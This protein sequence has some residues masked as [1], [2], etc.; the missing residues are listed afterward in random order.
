VFRR[1][2]DDGTMCQ[3]LN[4]RFQRRNLNHRSVGSGTVLYSRWLNATLNIHDKSCATMSDT[5]AQAELPKYSMC[6]GCV[7]TSANLLKNANG[8]GLPQRYRCLYADCAV[9]SCIIVVCNSGEY[10]TTALPSSSC[11]PT[12]LVQVESMIFG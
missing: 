2:R 6:G 11:A 1:C 4:S 10:S 8:V 9:V 12:D 3:E 5:E 7:R